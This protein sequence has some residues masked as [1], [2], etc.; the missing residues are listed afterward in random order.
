MGAGIIALIAIVLIGVLMQAPPGPNVPAAPAATGGLVYQA[1][2]VAPTEAAPA[3]SWDLPAQ[4]IPARQSQDSQTVTVPGLG[5]VR[6]TP[7]ILAGLSRPL[8]AS[9]R[10]P[11]ATVEPCRVQSEQMALPYALGARAEAV[12]RGPHKVTP[13]GY[14]VGDVE[15]RI[16]YQQRD[17]LEVR[18][19]VLRCWVDRNGKLLNAVTVKAV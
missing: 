18:Q 7:H 16:V 11:N 4:I 8:R 12:S 3:A 14:Y 17:Y 19:A 10:G 13:E 5:T 6:A 1:P 9:G 2:S 15:M